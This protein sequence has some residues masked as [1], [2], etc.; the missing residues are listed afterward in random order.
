MV[1]HHGGIEHGT[2]LREAGRALFP[3]PMA[4]RNALGLWRAV[5]TIRGGPPTMF[6]GGNRCNPTHA[7]ARS[8]YGISGVD[9][10]ITY[11]GRGFA[12]DFPGTDSARDKVSCHFG[13]SGSFTNGIPEYNSGSACCGAGGAEVPQ[14]DGADLAPFGGVLRGDDVHSR[15]RL[16]VQGLPGAR[17]GSRSSRPVY[18]GHDDYWI[19]G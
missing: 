4:R 3:L 15:C 8:E 16:Y 19:G 11:G 18:A 17:S 1:W 12:R 5:C 10:R 13:H 2:G 14:P 9:W 6:G 7:H